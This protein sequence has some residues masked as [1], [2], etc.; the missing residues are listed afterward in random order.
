MKGLNIHI[1][2]LLLLVSSTLFSQKEGL[3]WYFGV[4]AGL[5]FHTGTAVPMTNGKLSTVE[6]CSSISNSDGDLMLYTDGITVWNR[7]H[8]VMVNG[9]GLKG[10]PDA[11]QS[12]V[13]V[14]VPDDSTKYYI[15]T[16]SSLGVGQPPD[17]FRYSLVDMTLGNGYGGIVSN[18]KNK[19]LSSSTTERVTSVHHVNDYGVWVIMHEWESSRFK[20]FLVTNDLSISDPVISNVGTYHGYQG[21]HNRDGIGYMKA[22]PDGR[23]LAVAINGQN[24]VEVFD[25]DDATGFLA[26]PIQLPVDTMPYGVEFSA[27]AEFLYASERKGNKIYQWDMM[28]E[29]TQEIINSRQVVGVLENPFGGA[30][31]LASDGK[32][33]IARKSKFYLSKINFPY[34]PGNDCEFEEVGINLSGKQSKEGLP[35]FIQSYF[36]NLWIIPENFCIDEQIQFT[37]N[38]VIN[39]DSIHWNFGD[40]SGSLNTLWGD[41]VTHWF[42]Q[43]GTYT[44]TA[45]CYHLITQTELTLEIEILE[46]PD[47]ELGSDQLVCQGD[48]AHFFA[49]N[50]FLTYKWNNGPETFNPHYSSAIEEQVV[51]EVTNVCGVDYDTVNIWVQDPPLVGLGNDTVIEYEKIIH[52]DAGDHQEYLWHNG[53]TGSIYLA[54]YPGTYWVEV[55]DDLGCKG[56]DTITLTAIP[57]NIH[58]PNAF[59]PNDDGINDEFEVVATYD[60]NIRFEMVVFNRWGELIFTSRSMGNFWDGTFNGEPCPTE[61]YVWRLNVDTYEDNE[62]YSGPTQM[63]GTVMLVR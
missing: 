9:Q 51:V 30:M 1:V 8:Q 37:I 24:F 11:T 33:Y 25:F 44:V 38:S 53:T 17:G 49:G 59:S 52:L 15:F 16:V 28:G 50:D 61:V 39:I 4:N 54:D 20:S 5:R 12:G 34:L 32:I 47:V 42:S 63:T 19:L 13:I 23:K 26:N 57:F 7:Q 6:G 21:G 58:V 40:P 31:Q 48:T 43:P 41:T 60:V 45:S 46:L 27:G 10:S 55:W 35:T 29:T 36:N 56:S 18:K 62:F 22:S 2:L 3:N 14:P